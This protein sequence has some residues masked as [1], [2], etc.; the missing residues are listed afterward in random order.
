MIPVTKAYLPPLDEYTSY[1]Q[2]IW[3]NG[4]LTNRGSLVLELEQQLRDY[5]QV[6]HVLFVTN[7][8]L[9]LQI[10][11]KTLELEGEIITTP[12][13]YVATTTAIL[14][15]KCE[16]VFVDINQETFCIDAELIEEKITERTSAILATHVYGYPCDIEK[17]EV[18]AKKH[19]LKVIYD[20]AHCFG[21][22]YKGQSIFNYGDISITSFHATKLFH[23]IEGGGI[24][25]KDAALYEKIVLLHQF[26]HLY[27]DY[28]SIGTNAKSNEFQ[29]AMGLCNLPNIPQIIAA[30]KNTSESYRDLLKEL[31]LQYPDYKGDFIYNYAYFPVVFETEEQLLRVKNK[32]A[33]NQINAR[34]YFYPSLNTL[35]YLKKYDA[36]PVS[37][38]IARRVLCLPLYDSL[39]LNLVQEISTI[40]KSVC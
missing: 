29:A 14:W 11:I 5:L 9:A 33:D 27:D 39:S 36:C 15:E 1:L 13:S 22:K 28:L 25:T 26:G 12:F 34:R 23:T 2:Q 3:E 17:I 38:E 24:F 16:P 20:A 30:R 6:P 35:P 18:I 7:G 19:Q 21:V 31:P 37:E 8:M 4:W 40:I 32:L 10:A